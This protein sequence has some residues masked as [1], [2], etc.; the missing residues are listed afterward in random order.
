MSGGQEER[1]RR[2]KARRMTGDLLPRSRSRT[3]ECRVTS[4]DGLTSLLMYVSYFNVG[5]HT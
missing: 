5:T 4:T 1:K 2:A 3:S